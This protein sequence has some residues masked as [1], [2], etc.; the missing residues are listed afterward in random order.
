MEHPASEA[1]YLESGSS[2]GVSA[3]HC[4]ALAKPLTAA[5]GAE[6]EVGVVCRLR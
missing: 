6:R 1:A 3:N 2:V 5:L 4:G